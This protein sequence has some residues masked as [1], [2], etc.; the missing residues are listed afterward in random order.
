M[1]YAIFEDMKQRTERS[2]PTISTLTSFRL[3]TNFPKN[4]SLMLWRIPFQRDLTER[5]DKAFTD[6]GTCRS[7]KCNFYGNRRRVRRIPVTP[8]YVLQLLENGSS[9]QE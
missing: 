3:S 5:R 1:G 8:E 7:C 4:W 2:F 9:L 6:A